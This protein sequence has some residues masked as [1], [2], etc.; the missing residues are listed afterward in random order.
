MFL[1]PL[2]LSQNV[3][4]RLQKKGDWNFSQSRYWW[5]ETTQSVADLREAETPISL[6]NSTPCRPIGSPFV[7]F[8]HIHFWLT[9][10][11]IFLQAF[12]PKFAC[13]AETFGQTRVLIAFWESSDNQFGRPKKRS[14]QF[15][16]FFWKSAPPLEK[17]QDPRLN[18]RVAIWK[19][20][21]TWNQ[22]WCGVSHEGSTY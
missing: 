14:T 8:W 20:F 3:Y 12:F 1:A 6:R 4:W 9:D 10:S 7:L 19:N 17:F 22:N 16:K 15:S 21:A 11:K 13:G 18:P 2:P 5:R